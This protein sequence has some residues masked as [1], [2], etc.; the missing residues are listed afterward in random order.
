MPGTA[1]KTIAQLLAQFVELDPEEQERQVLGSISQIATEETLHQLW[2]SKGGSDT[3]GDGS[4]LR[5]YLTISEALSN[6]G[7][8]TAEVLIK[9]G[10][11]EENIT[12]PIRTDVKFIGVGKAG[13]VTIK[14]ASEGGTAVV[15]IAP[16][17]AFGATME[18]WLQNLYIE[19]NGTGLHV[20]NTDTEEKVNVYLDNVSFG[21][22]GGTSI[23]TTHGNTDDAIRIYA[24]GNMEEIEGPVY[25]VIKNNGDRARFNNLSLAGG[26][27]STADDIVSEITLNGCQVKHEG[28]SGGHSSQKLNAIFCHT[29]TGATYALL[30]TSDLA[31][32]HT[33]NIIGS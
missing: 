5:P 6:V 3:Y 2:V 32:S 20:D 15:A 10:E 30:D 14:D 16:G 23:L 17:T 26:L 29:L 31:G 9:P 4:V 13:A 1:D 11:Y 7:A 8:G 27:E 33:E 25:L 12:W 28:V 19:H 22:D 21:Q 24:N 18:A